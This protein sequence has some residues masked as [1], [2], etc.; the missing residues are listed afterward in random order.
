MIEQG[1]PSGRRAKIV[2]EGRYHALFADWSG[3]ARASQP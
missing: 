1:W 2:D 3:Q